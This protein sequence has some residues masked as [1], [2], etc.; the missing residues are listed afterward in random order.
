MSAAYL[1]SVSL[2]DASENPNILSVWQSGT[3]A[4]DTSQPAAV[5]GVLNLPGFYKE[6]IPF[7]GATVPPGTQAGTIISVTGQ[8]SEA[9]ITLSL[10]YNLDG[11][12]YDGSYLGGLASILDYG[13]QE[14]YLYV[15][16]GLSPQGSLGTVLKTMAA[17]AGKRSRQ[18]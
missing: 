18:G 12:L 11:F 9:E 13:A 4:L 6:P 15:I 7:S 3:M 8:S 5:T 17:A 14:T 1:F 16:Q 10:V 2:L